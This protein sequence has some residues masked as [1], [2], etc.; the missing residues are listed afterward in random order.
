MMRPIAASSSVD[1]QFIA[2][3][4]PFHVRGDRLRLKQV[5]LNFLSNA[6]KYNNEGGM[7]LVS[8]RLT[9]SRARFEVRDTGPGIPLEKRTR[10][11]V[12]FERLGAESSNIEG[13]G[14]G[15]ALCK[16]LL[17]AMEGSIG[18]ENPDGGGCVFWAEL[19]LADASELPQLK[20]QRLHPNIAPQLV[21]DP[22][23]PPKILAVESHDFDLQLLEKLLQKTTP[24]CEFL[25]AM[26]GDLGL[27]LAKEHHPDLIFL[28]VNLPDLST[29]DFLSRLLASP[30]QKNTRVVLLGTDLAS[31]EFLAL[32][33]IYEFE[34]LPKPYEPE[35]L[36]KILKD[37]QPR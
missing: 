26:Q 24:E 18:L 16:G 37:I 11:F 7:V 13:T 36:F 23:S 6:I 2:R 14:I 5:V 8:L 22:S 34:L 20:I 31:P 17:D 30:S 21:K 32:S 33:R 10:L 28:D 25:S 29:A 19:P 12:P 35:A 1:L 4:R 3:D 15:L 27:E 9:A